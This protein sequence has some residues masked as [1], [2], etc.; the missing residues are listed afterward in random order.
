MPPNMA[1]RLKQ[2]GECAEPLGR[3]L[4]WQWDLTRSAN[5]PGGYMP[6]WCNGSTGYV[7]LW[8][9]AH[10]LLGDSKYLEWAEGA[11]WNAAEVPSPIGNLCCGMAGQAYALLNLYR[12]TGE[13]A[14]LSRARD[15]ARYAVVATNEARTRKDYEQFALRPESLYKGELG[16]AVLAADLDRPEHAR[17]P[18]FEVDG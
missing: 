8:T 12:H 13:T 10:K 16:I 6:G 7:F 1:E 18:L 9:L 3:G 17:M 2:L 5:Q 11:A 15:A 4:R 14:W